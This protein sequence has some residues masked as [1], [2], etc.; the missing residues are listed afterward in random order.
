MRRALPSQKWGILN[1][2][3]ERPNEG[4]QQLPASV[5]HEAGEEQINRVEKAMRGMAPQNDHFVIRR[6]GLQVFVELAPEFGSY[7][8]QYDKQ[9]RQICLLSPRSG[10]F[11]YNHD[12]SSG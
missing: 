1:F 12:A 7:W 4:E 2:H 8:V 3:T 6:E 9:L 10:A 5:V 11:R